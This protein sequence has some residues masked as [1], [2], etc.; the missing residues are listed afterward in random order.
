MN[1]VQNAKTGEFRR[2]LMGKGVGYINVPNYGG[3]GV[4]KGQ[5]YVI[6]DP[7]LIKKVERERG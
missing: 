3:W 1:A 4:E 6:V 2:W 7:S 5:V